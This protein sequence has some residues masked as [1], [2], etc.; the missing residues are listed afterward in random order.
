LSGINYNVDRDARRILIQ[1]RGDLD[2]HAVQAAVTRLS[3]EVPEIAGY[4]S[5][6]DMLGFSGHVSFDDIGAIADGW[7]R[8]NGGN[9]RGRRTAV[10]SDDPFAPVY[11]KA[12]ALC[13]GGRELAVFRTLDEAERWLK[14]PR[15]RAQ[16]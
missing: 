6:C 3:E 5:I 1:F 12:I 4:D 9:D 16:R 11:I 7:R 13:F 10:V 2:G 14:S 8:F 15:P